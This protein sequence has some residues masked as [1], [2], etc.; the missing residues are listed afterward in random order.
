MAVDRDVLAQELRAARENRGISQQVAAER[1]GLSRTVIAQI[2]LAN[3][4]VSADELAKLAA[5]YGRAVAD[6]LG[7]PPDEDD[8]LLMLLDLAP[9]LVESNFKSNVRR[10]LTL[11]REAMALES[12]LGWSPRG[13]LP[14]YDVASPRS[15]A[16]AIEQG[17]R[18]AAQER[19]RVGLGATLPAAKLSAL[20]SWQGIR[21]FAVDLPENVTGLAAQ[22]RSIRPAVLINR[23]Q[24]ESA[25]RFALAHEYAHVLLDRKV[26]VTK[27]EN[28][29]ELVERR[30]DAFAGAFLLPAPGLEQALSTLN[31]G[32]PSRKTHVVFGIA[33]ADAARAEVRPSPGSQTVTNQDVVA[34]ARRFDAPYG[35]VV[36]R[37][38]ALGMISDADAKDLLSD[39]RV[40]AVRQYESVF[41]SEA[42]RGGSRNPNAVEPAEALDLMAEVVHLAIEAY[43]RQVIKKDRVRSVAKLL[44]L[45][46]L[47]EA[48]LLE[49]AEAGR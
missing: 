23:R 32:L 15:A 2:E 44:D 28:S 49:L 11:C 26:G 8:V 33:A 37:L 18:I 25:R 4:P 10:F 9:E 45:R 21:T 5:V 47:P 35:A 3:R 20:I 42:E 39:K 34:I 38:L 1:T 19:Q 27:R 16:G 7:Q 6:L 24:G 46:E 48:K 41:G 13:T 36:F 31:K 29:D 40:V 30:A 17:E 43:R 12:A 14:H 22:H